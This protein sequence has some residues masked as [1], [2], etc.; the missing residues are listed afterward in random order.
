MVIRDGIFSEL[1]A[2]PEMPYLMYGMGWF[3][4]P[5]RGH[6]M[7]HHGGN[8]DGFSAMVSFMPDDKL[9]LEILT[10]L[11][12]NL[13]VDSL[14]LEV[15]DRLL[16]LEPIDW[17]GRYKLKW[18]QIKEAVKLSNKKEENVLRKT[19]TKPSH[20]LQEFAGDFEESAYGRLQ[21]EISSGICWRL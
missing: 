7:I 13:M 10:N 9:G 8:N 6:R 5:Y 1:L 17:N 21:S 11:D 16:G 20:S 4:Q 19:G 15:Y 12:G 2:F 14:M 18:A 3:I